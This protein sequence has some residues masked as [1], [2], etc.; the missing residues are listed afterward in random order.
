MLGN[1]V[2]M[3]FSC[4]FSCPENPEIKTPLSL[5]PGSLRMNSPGKDELPNCVTDTD[6]FTYL[7]C[8]VLVVLVFNS[9]DVNYLLSLGWRITRKKT[10]R[11]RQCLFDT[12]MKILS[13]FISVVNVILIDRCRDNDLNNIFK[14]TKGRHIDR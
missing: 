2:I 14:K 1:L 8:S 10:M 9:N 11:R 3:R 4:S 13:G 6:D 5:S 7:F 12:I